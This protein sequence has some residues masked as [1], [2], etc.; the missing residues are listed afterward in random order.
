VPLSTD[1]KTLPSLLPAEQAAALAAT[2]TDDT[3]GQAGESLRPACATGEAGRGR[4]RLVD[5]GEG[6]TSENAAGPNPLTVQGVEAG[7]ERVIPLEGS[8][9]GWD[10]TS[11]TRLMKEDAR[12][13]SPEQ[14]RGCGD[15]AGPCPVLVQNGPAAT[16]ADPTD[17][18]LARVVEAWPELPAHIKAAVLA[19]VS[20]AC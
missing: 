8:S 6:E 12:R 2:G 13:T 3:E 9:G 5:T 4:L 18:G 1:V 15:G 19:L 17:A 20:T 14:A 16:P 7:C 10:R 11:D